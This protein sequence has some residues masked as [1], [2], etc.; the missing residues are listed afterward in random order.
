MII[1]GLTGSIGMGKTTVC[2][3]LKQMELP[4]FES[5]K[6]VH[7]LFNEEKLLINKILKEFPEAF[8]EKKI[9]RKVLGELVL[10]DNKKIKKL[11]KIV[12]PFVKR[13]LKKFL[14][15]NKLSG[16]KA[17]IVEVP[18]LYEI[19]WDKFC[20]KV[21]VVSCF[22][23]LQKKRVL[24]RKN[25]TIDKFLNFKKRQMPDF[26]KRKKAD[27]VINTNY[28]INKLENVLKKLRIKGFMYNERN[29]FRYRN[30]RF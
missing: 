10:C 12:H 30:N 1:I 15:N 23:Y 5:D 4:V 29:S 7:T 26:I 13:E 20:D 19:G 27:I 2:T 14:K 16:T 25:M 6:I 18:L 3:I 21:M 28:G 11:E 9:N 24:L 22:L 17:V 8:D